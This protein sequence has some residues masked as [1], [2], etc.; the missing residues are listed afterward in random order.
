MPATAQ[1]E[2]L[3]PSVV[4]SV[5]SDAEIFFLAALSAVEPETHICASKHRES[6][7][8]KYR[9]NLLIVSGDWEPELIFVNRN[10][11]MRSGSA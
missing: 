7:E 5:W 4:P 6:F 10:L 2:M 1:K 3:D 11:T 8:H 9:S